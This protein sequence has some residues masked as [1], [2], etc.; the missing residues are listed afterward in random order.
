MLA[1]E[2]T[3][4]NPGFSLAENTNDLLVGKRFFMGMSSCGL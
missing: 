3:G 2:F 4:R 1:A